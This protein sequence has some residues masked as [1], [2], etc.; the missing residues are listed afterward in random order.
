MDKTLRLMH[1]RFTSVLKRIAPQPKGR[2]KEKE[3][4]RGKR[5]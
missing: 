2:N 1:F 4:I 3:R 5:R